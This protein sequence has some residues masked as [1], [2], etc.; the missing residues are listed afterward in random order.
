MSIK[1]LRAIIY[2]SRDTK[3]TD[4]DLI[5]LSR[6]IG[7][8]WALC[9]L[10]AAHSLHFRLDLQRLKIKGFSN[11]NCFSIALKTRNTCEIKAADYTD[12]HTHTNRIVSIELKIVKK[13]TF[14]HLF[15]PSFLS[16]CYIVS[17]YI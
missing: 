1:H 15:D 9:T 3:L 11:T 7:K 17:M 2:I 5:V 12:T 6:N 4:S 8:C 16:I 14:A 13:R 10:N